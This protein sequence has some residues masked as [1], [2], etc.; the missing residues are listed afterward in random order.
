MIVELPIAKRIEKWNNDFEKLVT[1]TEKI[2]DKMDKFKLIF[3]S[4]ITENP[5]LFTEE[6]SAAIQAGNSASNVF[7]HLQSHWRWDSY[8]LL[9]TLINLNK[10]QDALIELK[11]FE[12]EIDNSI[13]LNEFAH[14][15]QSMRRDPPSG[16]TKMRAILDR[17]YS[18][19]TLKEC[20]DLDMHLASAFGSTTLRPPFYEQS[21]SIEVTWH[22]PKG[23]VRGL[24]SRA[25]QAK[26]LFQLLFVSFFEIDEIVILKK[27]WPYPLDVRM[28]AHNCV[29]VKLNTM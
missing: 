16:Y 20:K 17:E 24:L 22:I 14:Q 1:F 9:S 13:K 15:F 28:Y 19:Y 12:D 29:S 27:E 7:H 4:I 8:H 3:S 5:L 21:T 11:K 18:E 2:L 10:S 6:E 25:Y 26:A 23:S